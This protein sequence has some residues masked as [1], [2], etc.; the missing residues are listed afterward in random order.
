MDT[1]QTHLFEISDYISLKTHTRV[2]DEIEFMT[3]SISA[4]IIGKNWDLWDDY[5]TVSLETLKQ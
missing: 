4:G 2:S 3:L 1:D 5:H